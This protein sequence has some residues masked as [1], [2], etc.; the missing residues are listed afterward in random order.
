MK[1]Q[2]VQV[3]R[4]EDNPAHMITSPEDPPI[5]LDGDVATFGT[6]LVDRNREAGSFDDVR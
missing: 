6:E 4:N 2:H 3:F 5:H 1:P